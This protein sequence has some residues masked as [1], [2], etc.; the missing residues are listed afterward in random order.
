MQITLDKALQDW[1]ADQVAKGRFVSI[2]EAVAASVVML[3]NHDL[4]ED[5]DWALPQVDEG[6]AELDRGEG[7]PGK[8][9]F[10]QVR[11]RLYIEEFR[12]RLVFTRR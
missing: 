3:R 10:E 4:D 9:A 5:C 8:A 2:D 7:V 6:L 12:R 11:Q 1:L